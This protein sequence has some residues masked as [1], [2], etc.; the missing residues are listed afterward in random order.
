MYI[1]SLLSH[2][3]GHIEN[4]FRRIIYTKILFLFI[5][6]HKQE[7]TWTLGDK[8]QKTSLQPAAK[9]WQQYSMEHLTQPQK[10]KISNRGHGNLEKLE[11][12]LIK[13]EII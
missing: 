2:S 13:I 9:T 7:T 1:Y 12:V 3:P 4:I 11:K 5:T 6:L 10:I 8:K